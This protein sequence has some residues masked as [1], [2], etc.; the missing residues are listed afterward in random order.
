MLSKAK[1][2]SQTDAIVAFPTDEAAG[3]LSEHL[4]DAFGSDGWI[5]S[6]HRSAKGDIERLAE[7]GGSF[8]IVGVLDESESELA[9][10]RELIET[11]KGAGLRVVLLAESLTPMTMHALMRAGADDFA[12][13]PLPSSALADCVTRLRVFN[14]GSGAGG[15]TRAGL[16]FPVY[17][18]A[19]G[20]G[21]TTFSVNLAWELALETAKAGKKVALLDFNFQYGTVATYLDLPR[22]EAIYELLSDTSTLDEEGLSQA[23]T[24]YGGKLAILTAPMDVLPLDIIGPEDV[25][26]LLMLMRQDFDAIVVDLPQTLTHWSDLV[27]QESDEFFAMMHTDMR[28]A[29]NMLRFLRALKSEELPIEKVSVCLNRAPTFTD[30][31]GKNRAHRLEKSLGVDFAVRLPDGGKQVAA[32]CDHGAPLAKAAKS[33]PLRKEIRKIAQ[34]IV[35]T[36]VDAKTASAA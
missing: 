34:R 28:S 4:D 35:K 3:E 17:G 20:V 19:G 22:R 36:Y 13:L 27:L 26:A 2:F 29:Q 8:L 7:G 15:P 32:A 24:T 5:A 18:S 21:A 31:S 14:A 1:S 30:L 9:T 6:N 12:P 11:A 10:A 25:R 33:N 16:V 23:M